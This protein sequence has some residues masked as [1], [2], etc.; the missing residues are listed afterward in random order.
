[1]LELLVIGLVFC[2]VA[3]AV[4]FVGFILSVAAALIAL[5]FK[6]MGLLFRGVG[7]LLVAPVVLAVLALI[8]V[9]VLGP[10]ALLVAIPLLPILLLFGLLRLLRR[11]APGA[12]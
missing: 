4:G 6:L 5:P 8:G 9:V 11:P 7:C 10:F 2:A 1:M 12:R 3:A